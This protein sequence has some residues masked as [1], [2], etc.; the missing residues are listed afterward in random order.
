MWSNQINDT[1]IYFSILL[2]KTEFL[3]CE[4][5][6]EVDLFWQIIIFE[7]AIWYGHYF[8]RVLWIKWFELNK[9]ISL[10]LNLKNRDL[11]MIWYFTLNFKFSLRWI[12]KSLILNCNLGSV[13]HYISI[14]FIR[15]Y[16]VI[17]DRFLWWWD[18]Y[19][20]RLNASQYFS[21]LIMSNFSNLSKSIQILWSSQR[22]FKQNAVFTK[23]IYSI[24]FKRKPV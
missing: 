3:P 7:N 4:K 11:K 22:P 1:S 21:S 14:H 15:G 5:V 20:T 16:E 19:L 17:W 9:K 23:L 6:N 10:F 18:C 8:K 13:S 12:S 2:H 24:T